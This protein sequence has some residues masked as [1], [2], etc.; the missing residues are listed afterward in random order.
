MKMIL[1]EINVT[2]YSAYEQYITGQCACIL[3]KGEFK[4][5]YVFSAVL[6]KCAFTTKAEGTHQ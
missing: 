4:T 6:Y 1:S 3:A 2:H 5:I